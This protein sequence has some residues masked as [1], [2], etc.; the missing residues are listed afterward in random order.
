MIRATLA[1]SL[2]ADI[3][4]EALMLEWG[5]VGAV[6]GE[7]AASRGRGTIREVQDI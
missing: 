1:A 4:G 7:I 3:L 5:V 6:E 2:Q